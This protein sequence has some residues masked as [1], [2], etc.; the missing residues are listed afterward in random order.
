MVYFL[1]CG[2]IETIGL[3]SERENERKRALAMIYLLAGK[4]NFGP[5]LGSQFNK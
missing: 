3:T 2:K 5:F 4:I 1:E